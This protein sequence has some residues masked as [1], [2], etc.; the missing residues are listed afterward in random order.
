MDADL[1]DAIL[2]MNAYDASK[3]NGVIT[4]NVIGNWT[5]IHEDSNTSF[6]Y[7]AVEYQNG[8][9][10]T[11]SY[12]GTTAL[13]G[14]SLLNF[15][16]GDIWN[17]YG[18]GAGTA[19]SNDSQLAIKLYQSVLAAAG[20]PSKI[21]LTGH[22]MGGG[23]AGLVGDLYGAK[24][25]V[26]DNMAF[27]AAANAAYSV[28]LPAQ[29]YDAA[30]A[31]LVYG[32]ST[33]TP[34][35]EANIK[36]YYTDGEFLYYLD[37]SQQNLQ[38]TVLEPQTDSGGL[39][40]LQLHSMA[41]ATM[42][43][44]ASDNGLT[45]WAGVAPYLI[46]EL[47]NDTVASAAGVD[48]YK[49]VSNTS[50]ADALKEMIAYSA[51]DEGTMPFGD[52]AIKAFFDDA[53]DLSDLVSANSDPSADGAIYRDFS[54]IAVQY[55]GQLAAAKST[56]AALALGVVDND[57]NVVS[58][59]LSPGVWSTSQTE[60][61]V[62]PNI[63]GAGNAVIDAI[64]SFVGTSTPAESNQDGFTSLFR[65]AGGNL[66]SGIT[67]IK[68]GTA[69]GVTLDGTNS[70]LTYSGNAGGALLIGA[71]NGNAT[72]IGGGGTNIMIGQ[73]SDTFDIAAGNNIVLEQNG[74][75]VTLDS[76]T[77]SDT[78]NSTTW[79]M[80]EGKL[81]S[82]ENFV[83]NSADLAPLTIV[84]GAS[85]SDSFDF[86]AGT[87]K[88][89]G[90]F[91]LQMSDIDQTNFLSLDPEKISAYLDAHLVNPWGSGFG[92]QFDDEIVIINP[93]ATDVLKYNG[94]I[95]SDP[96]KYVSM[97]DTG[98]AH[99]ADYNP[100]MTGGTIRRVDPNN[101]L[102]MVGDANASTGIKA[103]F[104]DAIEKDNFTYQYYGLQS[105]GNDASLSEYDPAYDPDTED[106]MPPETRLTL[107]AMTAQDSSEDYDRESWD[108][109][110][111]TVTTHYTVADG[112]L[113]LIGFNAGDFGIN[114]SNN[115]SQ[116]EE[117]R[118]DELFAVSEWSTATVGTSHG[119]PTIE[120][121]E[122]ASLGASLS[123]SDETWQSS[124]NIVGN[125]SLLTDYNRPTLTA[126]DFMQA[127]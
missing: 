97:T 9:N 16:H 125:S 110:T 60:T 11:I 87:D 22:S 102:K 69:G 36:G 66:I 119:M 17:G 126:S 71:A 95:I 1:M 44:Y 77:I 41:L 64:M 28:S 52:V 75:T 115:S 99:Y 127:A 65:A 18:T 94:Q 101:H 48:Q 68:V 108:N 116:V 20:D 50:S 62:A 91:L 12:R 57:S 107:T 98:Q 90:V 31:S 35:S 120:G 79:N 123:S 23:L 45:K 54:D 43:L 70:A 88:N 4:G 40:G 37:R 81:D 82:A 85:G 74:G 109:K 2:A 49:N 111:G 25:V 32:T 30:V 67:E 15:L 56:D 93:T 46:P 86:E 3:V 39:S 96:T 117:Q 78:A 7:F 51:I 89:V 106:Y 33:P 76:S 27:E 80:V 21:T 10:Y 118:H 34:P 103:V 53:G 8:S 38:E 112:S 14:G 47:W 92:G 19:S 72:F 29:G 73:A 6:N 121:I 26:F 84:Y 59:D 100:N 113:S 63:V 122:P 42:L 114:F 105:A 124:Y 104:T 24:A 61:P 5:N 55:A 83:F 58:I 13:S